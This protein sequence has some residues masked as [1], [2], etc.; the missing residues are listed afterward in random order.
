MNKFISIE[1]T[2]LEYLTYF[3]IFIHFF[4]HIHIHIHNLYI[5]VGYTLYTN[6]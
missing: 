4:A 3:I 1:A 6:T 5:G 2:L